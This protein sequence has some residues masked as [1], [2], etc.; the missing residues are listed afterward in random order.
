MPISSKMR[1]IILRARTGFD[2][3]AIPF[4]ERKVVIDWDVEDQSWVLYNIATKS[5]RIGKMLIDIPWEVVR[6][7][8]TL[9]EFLAEVN[10]A[11]QIPN[12]KEF[13]KIHG[14]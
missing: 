1:K 6:G 2:T 9:M 10:A 5:H 13:D 12:K 7:A 4:E 14:T 8:G 11:V 3:N